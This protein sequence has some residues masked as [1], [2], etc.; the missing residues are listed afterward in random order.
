MKLRS[1][2]WNAIQRFVFSHFQQQQN[3]LMHIHLWNIEN[4]V[5]IITI[6]RWKYS[7]L[8]Q[9]HLMSYLIPYPLIICIW[10]N[11]YTFRVRSV[12][13]VFIHGWIFRY[14]LISITIFQDRSSSML[15]VVLGIVHFVDSH[16]FGHSSTIRF[17]WCPFF[18]RNFAQC[19]Y[20]NRF[21][22]ADINNFNHFIISIRLSTEN[23]IDVLK[24]F[25]I[26]F[27]NS[28]P[29]PYLWLKWSEIDFWRSSGTSD[30][31]PS[32]NDVPVKTVLRL[33]NEP[34]FRAGW[35]SS[36]VNSGIFSS[37]SNSL[38]ISQNSFNISAG[39]L[40][41]E[42][43]HSS[44]S[45]IGWTRFGWISWKSCDRVNALAWPAYET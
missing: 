9:Q 16:Q 4:V 44:Y 14:R 13:F 33:R 41:I 38:I 25:V 12:T 19:F 29:E 10:K 43:L 8:S 20:S 18:T 2:S 37:I 28:K 40:D 45:T 15:P 35:V 42:S 1:L 11:E 31:S 39:I 23:L 3:H 34:S 32:H 17:G 22:I 7:D 6:R 36:R 27:S 5:R 21:I 26:S 24:P 30:I